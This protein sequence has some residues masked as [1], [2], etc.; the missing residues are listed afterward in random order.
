VSTSK[1]PAPFVALDVEDY[2]AIS[3][4]AAGVPASPEIHPDN[5][6]WGIGLA[7]LSWV[8][9]VAFL[10][11]LSVIVVL[12]YALIQTWGAGVNALENF[13]KTDKTALFLQI[14]SVIP[15]HLLTLGAAWAI[16]TRFGKYPFWRSLGWDWG[17]RMGPWTSA[18][19][20]VALLLL[21]TALTKMFGGQPTDIDKIIES[22]TASRFALAFLATATAPLVEEVIYRGVIYSALQRAI[23]KLWAIIGVMVLFAGVH[24]PQY[25]DNISVIAAIGILSLSLTLVRAYSGRLLPCFL[26]HLVFNGIQS[27]IIVLWPYIQRWGASGGQKPA[28]VAVSHSLTAL[29]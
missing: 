19:L 4:E 27:I 14:V 2:A 25:I 17:K 6:P 3:K 24:V 18:G 13:L 1:E 10:F 9:S 21:G 7:L 8:A 11:A 20:A 26:I 16:V 23:G 22:S 28:L 12:P 29:F 15:A 5:P